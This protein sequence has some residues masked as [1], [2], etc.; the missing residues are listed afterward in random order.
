VQVHVTSR[1][2][3]TRIQVQ[4]RLG[5]MAVT[6]YSSILVG[7]GI[8][9]V[10]TILA[11]GIGW[12]G[13]GLEAG[14]LAAGWVPG[15]YALTRSIFSAVSRRKRTDLEELSDRIAEIA[16]ESTRGRLDDGE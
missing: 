9:G 14:L 8:G 4:E 16:A 15:M 11:I 5:E 12:L 6:L 2:G 10:A 1:G 3:Q 7:G 13:T